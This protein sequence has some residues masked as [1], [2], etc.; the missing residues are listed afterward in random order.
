MQSNNCLNCNANVSGN[1]CHE[2]GQKTDTHRITVKHFITHD[3]IHGVWHID[4]GIPYTLKQVFTRPGHAS[5]DY[6]AGKRVKFYNVFYLSL[7]VVGFFLLIALAGKEGG[8]QIDS[9]NEVAQKISGILFNYS[10]VF[11]FMF[12]PLSAFC[13]KIIFDRMDLNYAEHLI[14]AGFSILGCFIILLIAAL[15]GKLLVVAEGYIVSLCV[16]FYYMWAYRQVTGVR[17]SWLGFLWRMALYF[18]L[19][20]FLYIMFFAPIALYIIY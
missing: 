3:L 16:P 14:I 15:I 6:I 10:K 8:E 4:K 20:V 9:N 13:G 11:I 1:F 17:Y 5:M 7:L 12:I 18:I 19:V 2:C